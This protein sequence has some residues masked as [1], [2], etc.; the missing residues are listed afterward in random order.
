M[1][2]GVVFH[3]KSIRTTC[4]H[5]LAAVVFLTLAP[6]AAH[7]L[8]S[9]MGYNPTDDG[10]TLAYAR[11]ILAGQIPHRD[12]III[13]PFLS[14][15]MH[16]P[17]VVFGG[18]Q[19]YW[20]SRL[21]VWLQIA[22]IAWCGVELTR[23]LCGWPERPRDCLAL[24]LAAFVFTA[25]TFPIMAWH[26]ID[27]LFFLMTGMLLATMQRPALRY[28]GYFLAAYA[29]LCKQSFVMAAPL[30]LLI[31]GDWR[32][33]KCWA[34]AAAPGLAYLA[35]LSISGA[36]PDAFIQFQSHSSLQPV[37]DRYAVHVNGYIFWVYLA[38]R[39]LHGRLLAGP[40]RPRPCA[41]PAWAGWVLILAMPVA[42]SMFKL[43]GGGSSAFNWFWAVAG[44]VVF[45]AVE[46]PWPANRQVTAAL[47]ALLAGWSVSISVG[48]IN[49]TLAGGFLAAVLLAQ[50]A[51]VL[52]PHP[53]I[54]SLMLAVLAALAGFCLWHGR[55]AF[56]YMEKPAAGL[57]KPLDNVFPGGGKLRTNPNTYKFL[58]DLQRAVKLAEDLGRP[59][60]ILPDLPGYWA[61]AEQINPLPIDWAK[62]TELTHPDVMRRLLAAIDG[63]RGRVTF[64]V[65]K[66]EAFPLRYGFR[67]LTDNVKFA[68]A[69]HVRRNFAKVADTECFELY[70]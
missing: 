46:R 17:A 28:A 44:I 11:R 14:P 55:Q 43:Y 29:Y 34:S 67:K 27:G 1:Q 56:V 60:A 57:T 4:G 51:P 66:F 21:T 18:G 24:A 62:N 64:L 65:Q 39:L 19:M 9:G 61:A 30:L 6:L 47:L 15:V 20:I 45:A 8:F 38:L 49:P 70:Q 36:L 23:R 69:L 5:L 53:R 41:W 10:F 40:A 59:Y 31:L 32:N 68:V 54:A 50:G 3:P 63:Q 16:L 12:F 37:A 35:Y 58:L 22:W 2:D 42:N 33:W 52:R 7:W 26:T 25:N 48:A 13:R